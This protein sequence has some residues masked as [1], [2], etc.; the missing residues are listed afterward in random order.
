MG[1]RTSGQ[2]VGLQTIGN[3]QASATTL[4]TTQPNSDLTLDPNGSGAVQVIASMTMSGDFTI[5]NQGDLR[6]SEATANGTNY[7]AMQAAANM[8]TNYTITWPAAV[9]TN[10]GYVLSSAT[11]G[12]LSWTAQTTAGISLE[13]PGSTATVHY[14]IFV[15]NAGSVVSGQS[16]TI[17]NRANLTF[18]PSTGE[19]S[20]T[21]GR[22]ANVIGASTGSGTL[23][24]R[25]TSNASKATASVLMTDGVASTTTSTGTL[26][27][28]GG[29][30][31]SGQITCASISATSIT[32]TSSITFKENVNP[33][34]NALDM[35]TMLSG[36]TYDRKDGTSSNE[37]GLIAED[38]FKI[39]PNL[40]QL[41][42]NGN[43]LGIKYTKL[44]AYLIESVK[45]L[46]ARIDFLESGK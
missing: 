31:V 29:V 28:T 14:P 32:E 27:V 17:Q 38:V 35:I 36:V 21:I 43:P 45:S 3:I 16:T 20:S 11:D 42:E 4:T 34:M 40:V 24:L 37:A 6:L 39:L 22:F 8:A 5:Q 2:Q 44:T 30:G 1:R 46:K 7:I 23:T 26:V 18:I 12:T 10:A 9:T 19:L 13:D 41:D 33:I 15:T 25:G